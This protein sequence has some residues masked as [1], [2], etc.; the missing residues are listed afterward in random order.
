MFEDMKFMVYNK[1]VNNII[2][3]VLEKLFVPSPSK[4]K[5]LCEGAFLNAYRAFE[6]INIDSRNLLNDI[7]KL[8]YVKVPIILKMNTDKLLNTLHKYNLEV[9]NY[10][11]LIVQDKYKQ[12]LPELGKVIKTNGEIQNELINQFNNKD[13]R[14]TSER[15]ND[16]K[17][18]LFIIS[19]IE[20]FKEDWCKTMY[21]IV[22]KYG[23]SDE[24]KVKIL[25]EYNIALIKYIN[26][27]VQ[28]IRIYLLLICKLNGIRIKSS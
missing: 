28:S 7:N 22:D 19:N 2:Y 8:S 23:L 16:L 17:K 26:T 13:T 14:T 11:N 18:V 25:K 6:P 12:I 5:K 3:D 10:D 1:M 21:M 4:I 27:M 15:P 9:F 24:D 20:S